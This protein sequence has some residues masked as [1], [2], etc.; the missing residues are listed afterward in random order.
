MSVLGS[1]QHVLFSRA[2]LPKERPGKGYTSF[3]L[4]VVQKL[5]VHR[6]EQKTYRGVWQNACIGSVEP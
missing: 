1:L 3:L 6:T 4:R 5:R 2:S